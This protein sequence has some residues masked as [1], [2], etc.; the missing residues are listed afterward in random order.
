MTQETGSLVFVTTA[1]HPFTP[2]EM[3]RATY[4]LLRTLPPQDLARS[5]VVLTSGSI[6]KS[7]FEGLFP[8]VALLQIEQE[9]GM[10]EGLEAA[11]QSEEPWFFTS[12]RILQA[13]ER[14]A[15]RRAINYVEF[16]D[17]SGLGF[18]TIQEKLARGFLSEAVIA[19]R[20]HYTEAILA[21]RETRSLSIQDLKQFDLERKCYRDCDM[22][23]A[24]LRP[25][26]E[27][28]RR[29]F[30][31]PDEEWW[32]RVRLAPHP[33]DRGDHPTGSAII[34]P[35]TRTPI[36][37][38]N[39]LR[40][41]NN[42]TIFIQAA[43]GL[44]RDHPDYR[45]RIVL[46]CG[47]PAS[48]YVK[49]VMSQVPDDL[50]SRVDAPDQ[51]GSPHQGTERSG[52]IA[53][54]PAAFAPLCPAAYEASRR[55]AV[56][57]L[58]EANPSFAAGTPWVDEE[59]CLKFDGSARGLQGAL[60][61]ALALRTPL[62]PV[63][64]PAAI[65]PWRQGT[66]GPDGGT[67]V[68]EQPLVTVIIVNQ[69]EG[70][71]LSDTLESVLSQGYR[72]LEVIVVDDGS[73]DAF[74]QAMR[75]T[76]GAFDDA[77][78]RSASLSAAV[79]RG[80]AMNH[81]V[82]LA[83]GDYVI[84]MQSGD[85]LRPRFIDGAVSAL[86]R[87]PDFDVYCSQVAYYRDI[88]FITD[89]DLRFEGIAGEALVAG[90]HV[91]YFARGPWVGRRALLED[92]PFRSSLGILS[93]WGWMFDVVAAGRRVI[94]SPR[95]EVLLR[96]RDPVDAADPIN[97]PH[98]LDHLI[99]SGSPFP[100]RSF[101]VADLAITCT[102]ASYCQIP[103]DWPDWYTHMIENG[104]EPEMSFV[105]GILGHTWLGRLIRSNSRIA[106]SLERFLKW[107]TRVPP[108]VT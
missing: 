6:A 1:L 90:S 70:A 83:A 104:Y 8:G 35:D 85:L 102:G 98:L 103:R 108:D 4:D 36:V 41:I 40:E 100:R 99:V 64:L 93:D 69:N 22:I 26:A 46:P 91:N 34:R 33:V 37:F 67:P 95:V 24:Q 31:F 17:W 96:D 72:N 81:G 15:E 63:E 54:F 105:G 12:R 2:G 9:P 89:A 13:L 82:G 79:G 18:A 88:D 25:V 20:L 39:S 44:M 74:S 62:R 60:E 58:N 28:V 71:L 75:K 47:S 86:E 23:V 10:P 49:S 106:G 48:D 51:N 107:S 61:R 55:G 84:R 87:R 73:Q 68:R 14:E 29:C 5:V 101:P 66:A 57:V 7:A 3:G 38:A 65:H 43:V 59:N 32:P 16:P 21:L 27:D 42:P 19:V 94:C 30:G 50:L 76:L 92:V 45:G 53:V 80:A 78:V 52:S 11:P 97:D 77:R 56:V